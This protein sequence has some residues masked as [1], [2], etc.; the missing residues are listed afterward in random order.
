MSRYLVQPRLGHLQQVLHI[1][2][3]LKSNECAE[4]IYDT[5]KLN[6]QEPTILTQERA[7]HRDQ[8]MRSMYPDAIDFIP[9][10]MPHPLGKSM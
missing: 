8:V 6:I 7:A 2:S 10:N 9:P 3:F 5:T 4:L 1:F